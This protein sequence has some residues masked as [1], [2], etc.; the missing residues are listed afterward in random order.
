MNPGSLP[1]GTQGTPYSQTVSATGGTGPY[2][3]SVA[4]GSLPAGLTLD[5]NTGAISGTPTGSGSSSALLQALDS[6][7]NIGSRSYTVNIGTGSLTVNPATLPSGTQ[8]TPY[9]QTVTATG[10]NGSYTYSISSGSLPAGLGLNASTGAISGTPTGSGP[11]TFT[12]RADDTN[13]NFGT[14]GYTVNIGTNSL[15]VNPSTLPSGTQGVAYN[16]TVTATGGTAPYTFLLSSGSLPAGLSLNSSTGAISGTPTGSGVSSFTV[17]AVDPN[18]N[19]GSRAYSLTIGSSIITVGPATLPPATRG[20]PYNQT[21]TAT[22]GT[23]PYTFT[24]TAGSLPPGL[25]LNSSTGAIS[26]T[27]T[28]TGDFTFTVQARNSLGNIGSR[29]YTIAS[30][31]NPALDPEVQGLIASQVATSRRLAEGQLTNVMR[32]LEQLHQES[33]P[34]AVDIAIAVAYP[35]DQAVVVS[36][37]NIRDAEIAQR[38]AAARI[39]C[40]RD[41]MWRPPFSVWAGGAIEI[42]TSYLNGAPEKQGYSTQAVT[43]GID[44]RIT[45][46]IAVGFAVGL[47]SDKSTVTGNG[48]KNAATTLAAL[49]YGSYRPFGGLYVDGLLGYGGLGFDSQRWVTDDGSLAYG[50]RSGSYWLAS[51]AVGW[52]H[53]FGPAMIAPYLRGEYVSVTLRGYT[54][55]GSNLAL[56]YGGM[57]FD[58]RA[59][60]LGLRGRYDFD[61]PWAKVSPNMRVEYKYALDSAFNQSMFYADLG[62]IASYDFAQ[63]SASR[64]SLTTTLGLTMR[65]SSTVTLDT[66]YGFAFGSNSQ[67][68]HSL[69]GVLRVGY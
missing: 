3:F 41:R 21:V 2:T 36:P 45:R 6:V 15:T 22:G 17:R 7:G 63:G 20:T 42:G 8:G 53:R 64:S 32:R 58:S 24:I 31:S 9:S 69:R 19:A 1:S 30:R 10:G 25:S 39:A 29:T 48:T 14:R 55:S 16:Q 61:L 56:S 67:Q 13:G 62:P 54:E 26:G 28:G 46:Q 60:V 51:V 66:E 44:W 65:P 11:S 52:E 59:V 37:P 68:T 18:G 50:Q 35:R 27:P 40:E 33:D 12:V 49:A 47:G 57:S 43:G 5:G 38:T 34:C 4:S 23:G